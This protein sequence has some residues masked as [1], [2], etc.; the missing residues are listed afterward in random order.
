MFRLFKWYD[1]QTDPG[2]FLWFISVVGVILLLPT[3]L[4]PFGVKIIHGEILSLIL[5]TV[6]VGSR[7]LYLSRNQS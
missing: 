5:I 1:R 3:I 7:L 6:L 4:M 2:R